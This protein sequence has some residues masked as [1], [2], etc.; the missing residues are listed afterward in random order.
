MNLPSDFFQV[1]HNSKGHCVI[2]QDML[3]NLDVYILN[4]L[5]AII[6]FNEKKKML[7]VKMKYLNVSFSGCHVQGRT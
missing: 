2:G 1:L 7:L 3:K 6:H 4:R 5:F